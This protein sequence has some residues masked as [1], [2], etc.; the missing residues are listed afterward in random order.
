MLRFTIPRMIISLPLAVL[1]ACALIGIN[2]ASYHRSID[3]VQTI[4]YAQ[5]TRAALNT[6][7][8]Q[9]LDAETGQRG[10]LLT[11]DPKY[12]QPYD[13]AV[14]D[15]GRNLSHLREMYSEQPETLR[16]FSD[17][18]S[19]VTRKQAEL[20]LTVRLRKQG[21][22]DAWKVVTLTDVGL[23]QMEAIRTQITKLIGATTLKMEA[24]QIEITRTLQLSRIA[25]ALVTLAGLLAFY[26][27]LQQTTALKRA[28]EREQESLQRERDQLERQVLERT[29]RLGALA[30]HLQHVREEERGHL[31]RELHDELGSLLT[32]AKLD[33]TRLR[34]KLGTAQPDA[35]ERLAH[36]T[37]TLNG[38]IALSRRIIEDLRPSSLSNLG[39]EASLEILAREFEERSGLA[40]AVDIEAVD[41]PGA[42]QLTIYRL[43]QESLTNIGK[44][45]EAKQVTISLQNF[46]SHINVEVADDGKGFAPSDVRPSSHGL[47]G[48]RHRVEAAGGRLTVVSHPGRGTRIS[49]ALPKNH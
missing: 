13:M 33:V 26:Y 39:L 28:G 27:Y 22:E 3:S 9:L 41:L 23:E 45:A 38:G 5:R 42:T 1:A 4:T 24:S 19:H 7:L 11:G 15:I 14:A 18:A 31:A 36:L 46:T 34:S 8:Q 17:L 44:Y 37:T 48:M 30:T 32:A 43:V 12:L 21:A 2:E 25:I 16:L 35:L 10:F 29:E 40:I 6:L 20:D 49:A 47:V